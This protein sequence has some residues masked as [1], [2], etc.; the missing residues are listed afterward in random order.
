MQRSRRTPPH[1]PHHFSV[2]TT[3]DP[4]TGA[5]QP[6]R[7]LIP[8]PT[9]RSDK[10]CVCVLSVGAASQ[11]VQNQMAAY[12][13]QAERQ[14]CDFSAIE[15]NDKSVDTRC[16]II[17]NVPSGSTVLILAGH[18]GSNVSANDI[19]VHLAGMDVRP[20][21]SA[22]PMEAGSHAA[23]HALDDLA[24]R[25]RRHRG[26]ISNHH[27]VS[28][29]HSWP[30]QCVPAYDIE[31]QRV[32]PSLRLPYPQAAPRG[33]H[34]A[35]APHTTASLGQQTLPCTPL[36]ALDHWLALPQTV[37]QSPVWKELVDTSPVAAKLTELFSDLHKADPDGRKGL[38]ALL[39]TIAHTM[40][41]DKDFAA[42]ILALAP[43]VERV[44]ADRVSYTAY[45]LQTALMLREA[46]APDASA[47]TVVAIARQAYRRR[48]IQEAAH[49]KVQA[50]NQG[51]SHGHPALHTEELETQWALVM[52]FIQHGLDIGDGVE[53]E[54]RFTAEFISRVSAD[55]ASKALEQLRADETS[56]FDDFLALWT[57]WQAFL[58]RTR[59]HDVE[60]LKERLA[61]PEL[62]Q[63]F[64]DMA[65]G[66]L[67]AV[68]PDRTPSPAEVRQLANQLSKHH[69]LTQ[70]RQLT[71]QVL[72]SEELQRRGRGLTLSSTR[73]RSPSS[74]L[75]PRTP[76]A[77]G[78][79]WV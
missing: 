35:T 64:D 42:Q 33:H 69:E 47:Q 4:V 8:L 10:P 24:D 19:E 60:A 11:E 70:W 72:W 43:D 38:K 40:A 22:P 18:S 12:Q 51:K 41:I 31:P 46:S 61:A 52:H 3:S 44:C 27:F 79:P 23:H 17:D 76:A 48:W 34:T 7:L 1:S 57:P 66:Q 29:T 5:S 45:M 39:R 13:Q 25:I 68:E 71:Q 32:P 55:D 14:G 50:I 20:P 54:G 63:G 2:R 59:P 30:E 6:S 78:L 62:A 67:K 74:D 75:A 53:H 28:D 65:A 56:H 16:L 77:S 26:N 36:A 21:L 15:I 49:A 9:P 73:S 37:T 58:Q